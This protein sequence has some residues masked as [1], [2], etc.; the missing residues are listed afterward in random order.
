[1]FNKIFSYFG[2]FYDV[3]DTTV[4]YSSIFFKLKKW[5]E[6]Y[7]FRNIIWEL[8]LPAFFVFIHI[9]SFTSTC[10]RHAI[11]SSFRYKGDRKLIN[12]Y[13]TQTKSV[14]NSNF[15]IDYL[16]NFALYKYWLH[17]RVTWKIVTPGKRMS[18]EAKPRLQLTLVFEGWLFLMLPPRA[19]NIYYM[20]LNVN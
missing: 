20:I 14:Q 1:M 9:T 6:V 17:A 10:S 11:F 5:P 2:S 18:T 7:I 4:L 3:T 13:L 19:V 8:W 12:A 15:Q 16:K